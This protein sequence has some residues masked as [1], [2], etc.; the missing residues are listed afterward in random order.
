MV[1]DGSSDNT[2]SIANKFKL[3]KKFRFKI[4]KLSHKGSP[5][6]SRNIGIKI[7][8]GKYLF[9]LDADDLFFKNKLFYIYKNLPT[10]NPDVIYHDVKIRHIKKN[11]ISKKITKKNPLNDLILNGNKIILSSSAIKKNLSQKKILD[12]MKIENLFLW[13]IVIFGYKLLKIKEIFL[14]FNIILGVY[15]LND[16]SISKKR[17]LH[18]INTFYL[19]KKYEKYLKKNKIKFFLKKIKIFMSFIKLSIVEKNF[20]FFLSLLNCKN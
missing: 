7:S 1:D 8:K 9:F 3:Q 5:A 11:Y 16:N 17:Y 15:N 10:K 20:H 13:K 2:I 19:L 18:F 6:R 12:L 4:I 14:L